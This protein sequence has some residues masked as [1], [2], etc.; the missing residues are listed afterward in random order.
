MQTD[1]VPLGHLNHARTS[2]NFNRWW[3]SC[4]AGLWLTPCVQ[5]ASSFGPS[6]AWYM[7]WGVP[8][9]GWI[10]KKR[11]TKWHVSFSNFESF[12]FAKPMLLQAPMFQRYHGH[13]TE[14][15]ATL[16]QDVGHQIVVLEIKVSS[17]LLP[18]HSE[19]GQSV[20]GRSRIGGLV[21]Q[22]SNW[23][24]FASNDDKQHYS[25]VN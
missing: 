11:W 17:R 13:R 22:G 3:M 16:V 24:M 8:N 18:L 20:G 5:A 19:W 1:A 14:T 25:S 15:L 4:I 9:L 21:P 23:E 2:W 6:E 7:R 10:W 12:D